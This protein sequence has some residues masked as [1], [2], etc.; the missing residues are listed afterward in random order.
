MRTTADAVKAVLAPGLDY[1][2][3][4]NPSLLPFIEAASA[5]VDEIA[6]FEVYSNARLELIERWYAAYAYKVSD[7]DF[8]SRSTLGA[9]GSFAG[10]TGTG[11]DAN[12]YGQMVKQLDTAGVLGQ[13]ASTGTTVGGVW[14]GTGARDAKPYGT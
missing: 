5:I 9:S 3:R 7:K 6:A 4:R 13:V 2:T 12:L 8:T 1:D 14:L 11:L 10:Q